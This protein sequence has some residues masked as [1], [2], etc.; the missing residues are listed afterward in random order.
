MTKEQLYK[1]NIRR[2]LREMWEHIDQQ[3]QTLPEG[4]HLEFTELS[5][6]DQLTV[7]NIKAIEAEWIVDP[8]IRRELTVLQEDED[9]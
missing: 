4:E 1:E 8:E 5:N 6:Q 3:L 9:Q 2:S 7:D